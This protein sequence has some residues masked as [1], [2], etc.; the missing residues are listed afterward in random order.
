[1]II[2]RSR[3]FSFFYLLFL[4]S[5]LESSSF[6][7]FFFWTIALS[8]RGIPPHINI[9]ISYGDLFLL[10]SFILL[11]RSLNRAPNSMTINPFLLLQSYAFSPRCVSQILVL[12]LLLLLQLILCDISTYNSIILSIIWNSPIKDKCFF[13]IC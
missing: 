11:T 7:L 8:F 4:L 1:M 3:N 9:S 10:L 2:N 12:L 6:N 5:F 13:I